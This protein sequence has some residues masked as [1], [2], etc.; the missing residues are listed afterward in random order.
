MATLLKL[1][2]FSGKVSSGRG[3]EAI[4][5]QPAAAVAVLACLGEY[6]TRGT[7][8]EFTL[9]MPGEWFS[10]IELCDQNFV[11]KGVY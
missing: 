11:R 6:G 8:T 10:C 5:F 2:V 1:R 4:G 7:F 9:F 3:Q